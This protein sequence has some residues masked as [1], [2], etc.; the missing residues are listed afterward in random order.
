MD[1]ELKAEDA[2]KPFKL[3]VCIDGSE[4]SYRG[5]RYVVR[6]GSG[7]DTD[8]T[9]LFIRQVDKELHTDGLDMRMARENMLEWGLELPGM[10]SLKR[11][12]EVLTEMGYLDGDWSSESSHVD[13]QGDPLGDNIVVYSNEAGR[14]VILKLMVAPS[15]D[16]GIID[17]CDVGDYDITVVSSA[18]PDPETE[19][20]IY[21]SSRVSERVATECNNSVI[22]AKSLEENHG[23]LICL[24][25]SA[26]SLNTAK[27]DAQMASRCKCPIFL[28]S[29]AKDSEH[30]NKAQAIIDEARDLIEDA[31]YV[32]AGENIGVGDPVEKIIEEGANYSLIVLGG[33]HKEGFRRFFKSS[34]SYQ[35]L[36]GTK[37][38][39]MISR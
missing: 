24:S 4:E 1:D 19:K 10:D 27:N 7:I 35:I 9:L 2:P 31:G 18:D 8:L 32:V 13:V 15:P 12:L 3:L 28:Y 20:S 14:K 34:I 30:I 16:L 25:G 11:G 26:S 39:V 37:N 21:F 6:L 29:V 5:L 36:E 38:S 17:E 23:H 33:E 22:V